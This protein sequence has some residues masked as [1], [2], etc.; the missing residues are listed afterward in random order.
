MERK[1]GEQFDYDGV[2]L[3]VARLKNGLCKGCYFYGVYINCKN[4][5]VRNTIGYCSPFCRND[6][7]NV[8]FE[9]VE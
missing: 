2:T 5:E 3:E 6:G 1:I 4:R 9:E 8:I 7:N